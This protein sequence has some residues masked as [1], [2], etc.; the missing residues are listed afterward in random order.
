MDASGL[1]PGIYGAAPDGSLERIAEDASA[2]WDGDWT[3][4]DLIELFGLG[5]IAAEDD[6]SLTLLLA[7]NELRQL[8]PLADA[9]SFDHD[10][11]LIAAMLAM[12][13]FAQGRRDAQIA[14]VQRF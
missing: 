13:R 10:E 6:D 3:L 2:A 7:Q 5:R 4:A 11:G 1:Q 9:Q 8:K 14:F 12:A